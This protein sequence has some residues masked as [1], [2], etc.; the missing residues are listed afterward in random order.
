MKE[1]IVVGNLKTNMLVKNISDY[2]KIINEKID[3][4]NVVICPSNIYIPYFLRQ[5]YSVGIQNIFSKSKGTYTGEVTPL[6]A[7]SMGIEYAIIGHSDRRIHLKETDE[8]INKKIL[9]CLKYNLKVI[10]CVGETNEDKKMLRIINVLKKQISSA[11]RNVENFENIY[12]AYE[13]VWSI[14]TNIIPDNRDIKEVVDY[15][16]DIVKKQFK[17]DDIKVLYGGS[18]N[19]NNI[20]KI[21]EVENLSGLLIGGSAENPNDFI[22]IIEEVV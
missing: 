21:K 4:K 15:I 14:G 7:A 1:Y 22:K 19:K 2:L 3:N 18:V 10:L 13:P 6:Q 12:I 8:D 11:L 9:E 17:Y 5:K 20:S 16:K